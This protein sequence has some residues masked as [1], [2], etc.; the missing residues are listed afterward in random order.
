MYSAKVWRSYSM[1]QRNQSA[2]KQG[3]YSEICSQCHPIKMTTRPTNKS[4]QP[5]VNAVRQT[6]RQ[7]IRGTKKGSKEGETVSPVSETP[8]PC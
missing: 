8:H 2:T 5:D 4:V 3:T 6:G 7:T 1:F